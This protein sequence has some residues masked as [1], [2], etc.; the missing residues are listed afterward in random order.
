MFGALFS[1]WYGDG[2]RL[3]LLKASRRLAG[4][5]DTFSVEIILRTWFAPFRQIGTERYGKS[6]DAIVRAWIDRT[7]SRIIG[8]IVRTF[9]L[10]MGL[11]AYAV[12]A[13][14]SGVFLIAW[15]LTPVVSVLALVA[16]LTRWVPNV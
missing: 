5:L 9:V 13:V 2:W 16:A 12:T 8:G 14:L 11:I 15:L 6:V 4:V 10:I 1:W 7:V 3:Q